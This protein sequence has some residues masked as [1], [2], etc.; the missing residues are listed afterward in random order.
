MT[1]GSPLSAGCPR[2]IGGE[3]GPPPDEGA[4]SSPA[5][6]GTARTRLVTERQIAYWRRSGL[7]R[8]GTHDL[9][10]ARTVAALRRAGISLS[11]IRTAVD[12]LRTSW[13][14]GFGPEPE[15]DP[16]SGG[17]ALPDRPGSQT[18]CFA[19]VAGEL[20]IRHP[21]G[22][23]EGDRRPGQ[24]ILDGILPLP[25]SPA[26]AEP[27]AAAARPRPAVPHAPTAPDRETIVRFV[28][29]EDAR[30]TRR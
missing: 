14:A 11:R 18:A 23:W 20:F 9:A 21:D 13:T 15:F 24:L 7:V 16:L 4:R 2:D 28:T 29:R 5:Q 25:G 12:R 10:Q 8:P 1:G 6:P 30:P 19:V 26:C 27:A 22:F 17:F 3:H